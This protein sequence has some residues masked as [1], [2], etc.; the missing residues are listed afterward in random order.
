MATTIST[1]EERR[2]RRMMHNAKRF[3]GT[4]RA[5]PRLA[6]EQIASNEKPDFAAF[7]KVKANGAPEGL[8]PPRMAAKLF[9]DALFHIKSMEQNAKYLQDKLPEKS[10]KFY[11]KKQW[12]RQM[13]EACKRVACRLAKG[14]GFNANCVG[15]EAFV[16]VLLQ[17]A[18]ELGWNRSSEM[19]S[20]LPESEKDRDFA[21]VT[22]GGASD[23]VA[24]L[25][26][27]EEKS[28]TSS[29]YKNWFVPFDNSENRLTDHFLRDDADIEVDDEDD[30]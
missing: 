19:W 7:Y 8:L 18:F 3:A 9:S 20:D 28:T 10:Q 4:Y 15:E 26:R 25:W 24:A 13:F 23:E 1:A 11:K 12:R 14:Q 21:R 17:S 5:Y 16:H 29:Q 30:E 27:G 2:E 6:W 22:R